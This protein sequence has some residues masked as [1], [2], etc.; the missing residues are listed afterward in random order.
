MVC[1]GHR[2]SQDGFGGRFS[3]VYNTYIPDQHHRCWISLAK[4]TDNPI[5]PPTRPVHTLSA[6]PSGLP[7][8]PHYMSLS[9]RRPSIALRCVVWFATRSSWS[10]DLFDLIAGRSNKANCSLEVHIYIL[11][12]RFLGNRHLC[13]TLG[14]SY[15]QG[16]LYTHKIHC[17]LFA[18]G[19]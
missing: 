1:S 10:D 11:W 2:E 8:A 14:H 18:H 4:C 17:K 9:A 15:V 19:R 16:R 12:S 7:R 3:A 13:F 6:L 5:P